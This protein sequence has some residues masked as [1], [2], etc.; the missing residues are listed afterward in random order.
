[1]TR[2][3]T[4]RLSSSGLSVTHSKEMDVMPALLHFPS[5][6]EQHPVNSWKRVKSHSCQTLQALRIEVSID[7]NLQALVEPSAVAGGSV[8]ES[9]YPSANA[10]IMYRIEVR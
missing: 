7:N 4:R 2:K 5:N 8:P 3:Y 6:T 9:A 1:V 10:V